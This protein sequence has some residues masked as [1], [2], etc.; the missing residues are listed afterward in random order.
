MWSNWSQPG[1]SIATTA[2]ATA[3]SFAVGYVVTAVFLRMISVMSF[4]PFVIYRVVLG[5]LLLVLLQA[6]W[7]PA[8][9]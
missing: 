3:V 8:T 9:S 6:G 5:L 4:A 1:P 7:M 2:I